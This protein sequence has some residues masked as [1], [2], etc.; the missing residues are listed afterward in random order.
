MIG[1]PKRFYEQAW[2]AYAILDPVIRH[3]QEYWELFLRILCPFPYP[4][5]FSKKGRMGRI[6]ILSHILFFLREGIVPS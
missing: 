6:G 1:I 3:H 4:F 2:L 5:S